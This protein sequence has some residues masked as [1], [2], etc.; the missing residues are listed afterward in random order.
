VVKFSSDAKGTFSSTADCML[1]PAG[2]GKASCQLTYTPSA[3]GSGT[4]KITAAYQGDS[5]HLKSEGSTQVKVSASSGPKGAAPNTKIVKKPQAKTTS[6]RARF[7]F[8]SDQPGSQFQCKLDKKPFKACRSPFKAKKL[9][10]GRHLFEV[11]AVN[12]AGVADPTPATYR[13][14]IS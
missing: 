7:T 12:A 8:T 11:K 5:A 3:V 4:D 6:R 1:S 9:K 14:R 2:A 13:W 10:K